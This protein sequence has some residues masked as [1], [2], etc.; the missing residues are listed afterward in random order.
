MS[1]FS[2]LWSARLRAGDPGVLAWHSCSPRDAARR[3]RERDS[4]PVAPLAA[5]ELAE[6]SAFLAPFAPPAAVKKN[7]AL[8]SGP[9]A[10]VVATGQQAGLFGG[11][12][13]V[14]YKAA[15]AIRLAR[16]LQRETG[17]PHVPVFWIASDD[18][19]FA[20]VSAHAWI[21]AAGRLRE[22]RVDENPSDS[23]KP[24]FARAL[25]TEPFA[26]LLAEFEASTPPTLFREG[27]LAALRSLDP[28]TW[29]SQFAS[30]L[31]AWF[32]DAGLVPFV[33]RMA[34][35][36]RRA[37]GIMRAEI[38]ARGATAR[39]LREAGEKL[40]AVGA[41]G[42]V[43]HRAGDEANFF[44]DHDGVR[45]KVRWRG[46]AAELLHPVANR[47]LAIR[48]ADEL[49][50]CLDESPEAFSP[51]A[52]LRPVVQDAILPTA[53]YVGGPAEVVYHAQAGVLYPHF[54]VFRPA[55][56]PRPSAMAVDPRVR[57]ILERWRLDP[58]EVARGG[59]AL[60]R[61]TAARLADRDGL[62]D[63]ASQRVAALRRDVQALGEVGGGDTAIERAS[64]RLRSSV[65]KGAAR[66]ERLVQ[67]HL[68]RRDA[69]VAAE[70][71]VLLDSLFPHGE[72]QERELGAWSPMLLE[73]GAAFVRALPDA[74]DPMA[75]GT[76]VL[77]LDRVGAVRTA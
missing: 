18:H 65:E 24:V 34:W 66:I 16:D 14:L 15:A 44:V 60:L 22:Q 52:A 10:R 4:Q 38:A 70:L 1:G 17:E 29:E 35:A 51:N 53:A 32:G 77:E 55:V 68:L 6:W 13:L 5:G 26:N 41:K 3:S 11:P 19:D 72:P 12:A 58:A 59:P 54:D 7:L 33:P 49:G 42:V 48:T 45:A 46:D 71:E 61:E 23:G 75:E 21:D 62:R 9:R 40:E 57:R 20:E 36:R 56:V 74:L 28:T 76:A 31:L 2:A 8:L 64:A 67:E 73:G 47:T 25:G 27:V 69:Q 39:M 63:A 37:A 43:I 50:R 30:C